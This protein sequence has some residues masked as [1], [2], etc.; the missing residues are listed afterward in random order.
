MFLVF[1]STGQVATELASNLAPEAVFL[2]HQ[3]G[4]KG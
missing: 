2:A 3:P 1:G 4:V